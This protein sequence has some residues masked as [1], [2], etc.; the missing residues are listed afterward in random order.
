[1]IDD[2]KNIAYI[3]V[4]TDEQAQS[5]LGLEAQLEAIRQ[6]LGKKPDEVFQDDISG[7]R[8]DRPG[9]L[10]AL[11]ALHK[12]DTLIAAKH[13]RFARDTFLASWI[14]MKV[15]SRKAT[16]ISATEEGSNGDTPTAKLMRH[17]VQAFSEFERD[18]I[19]AR[20]K[21]AMSVLKSQGR[22]VGTIPYGYKLGENNTLVE[23]WYEQSMIK[24]V[25]EANQKGCTLSFICNQLNMQGSTTRSGSPWRPQYVHNILK[26]K[27]AK[28]DMQGETL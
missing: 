20:T 1:M 27:Y 2:M 22:R 8:A 17:V 19:A 6:Y 12:E 3:R 24:G 4:S 9:L 11:T 15:K 10:A 23:D 18:M 13:D 25:K 26:K 7:K 16:M 14:E 5:G 28:P 21:A